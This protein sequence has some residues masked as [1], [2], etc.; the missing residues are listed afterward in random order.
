MVFSGGYRYAVRVNTVELSAKKLSSIRCD[1]LLVGAASVDDAVVPFAG[2][3]VS[4]KADKALA[5]LIEQLDIS[6]SAGQVTRVISAEFSTPVAI[7]G[8]GKDPDTEAIRQAVGAA[9]RQLAGTDHVAIALPTASAEEV[10]AI[11]EGGIMG[12]YAFA[13]YK[14]CKKEPVSRLTVLTPLAKDKD[15]Q[16][17]AKRGE[18]LATAVNRARD[19]VNLAPND[20]FPQSF[21]EYAE[22]AAKGLKV[23]VTVMDENELS[24]GGY[25]GL[26][27]VGM[28]SARPPRLVRLEWSPARAQAHVALVGKGITFDSGGL[29]LKPGKGMETMKC[30]MGGAAAV[31]N[32]I[33]AAAE[34]K[35]P[36]K[37]TAWL[38]M[39]E[40]MPA[41]GAQR[42]GDVITMYDGTTVEV[43]N[44]DA[45]GRLVM[46]DALARGV[47]DKPDVI[48][49]VAT[50]TGAAI[51]ALGD[52]TAAVMGD[53]DLTSDVL[54]AADCAGEQF[55]HMPLPEY[56]RETLESPVADLKNIGSRMGGTLTAG[57]FLEHFVGD[58]RWAHLDIAGPA[59]CE[60]SAYG[61]THKGGTGFAVRT[62]VNL[63]ENF[64]PLN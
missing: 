41:G 22:Q 9:T 8:V 26:I 19:L 34:L 56:M 33:L 1:I 16:A 23:K 54:A 46:A 61:Y 6:S 7:V 20:L 5:E 51:V 38:A 28:G 59:Y 62:L 30:D 2:P 10:G 14:K 4:A 25:G 40:N 57:L 42:P 45:E 36:I 48:L 49:D 13:Q 27:G 39:A 31:L 3:A 17:A 11:V 63:L 55:W 43:L 44:T 52:R 50:L 15:A 64:E 35:L 29:S 53:A 32:T 37:V 24:K 12:A 58:T 47:E 18:I 21:A 60:E